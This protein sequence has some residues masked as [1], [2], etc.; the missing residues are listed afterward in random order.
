MPMPIRLAKKLLDEVQ[1]T[2]PDYDPAHPE[3]HH[4]GLELATK[5]NAKEISD[6]RRKL[7]LLELGTDHGNKEL[8][9]ACGWNTCNEINSRYGPRVKIFHTRDNKGLWAIGSQWL[10]RD[11]PNDETLG[12]DYM[13]QQFLRDQPAGVTCSIPLIKEMRVFSAPTD[14]IEFTLM[15]R[16]QG[17]R[18]DKIWHALRRKERFDIR[19]QLADALKQLR[20]FTAPGA[21]KVDGSRLYDVIIGH[22]FRRH[23]PTC[24]KIGY[25]KE[26]WF[27][28]IA[29][30]LRIGLSVQYKTKDLKT[31]EEKYQGLKDNFP[32]GEP[33][34][35]THA[36][37]NLANIIVKDGRIEAIIDWEMAGYY[38]WWAERWLRL[39][40]GTDESD[41]LFG[42]I[43]KD[44]YP[45]IDEET[46]QKQV[47]EP[48]GAVFHAWQ[49]CPREHA[50]RER[51][52]RPG[53]CQCKPYA[54]EFDSLSMGIVPEHRIRDPDSHL[55][56]NCFPLVYDP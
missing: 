31:I 5:D 4:K 33:Y 56:I 13:T 14:K 6:R 55:G 7:G 24:K 35:L 17:A 51:W 21:Q 3:Q 39:C 22:C 12:N 52:L 29:E 28:N 1:A 43:W 8:C 38:P 11:E 27:E 46:F 23:A 2:N 30:E 32:E 9:W 45:E 44:I 48:V 47:V 25:T 54:G 40:W 10:L 49:L 53:F 15:S 37:L 20:K 36:D 26:E 42:P 18:L 41:Q 16:A 34:V 50:S 19:H